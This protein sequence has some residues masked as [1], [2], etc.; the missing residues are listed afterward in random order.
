[1]MVFILAL[2]R[3]VNYGNIGNTKTQVRESIKGQI[4]KDVYQ[5]NG[6]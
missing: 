1:M 4:A 2:L 3:S 5:P 6:R